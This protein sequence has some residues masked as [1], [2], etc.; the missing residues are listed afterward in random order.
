MILLKFLHLH[1]HVHVHA[2]NVIITIQWLGG[3][4]RG[5]ARD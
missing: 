4:A 5:V 3:V 1:V 2:Y